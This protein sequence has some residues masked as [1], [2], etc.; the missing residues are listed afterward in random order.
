MLCYG[1]MLCY[2]IILTSANAEL[3]SKIYFKLVC[4]ARTGLQWADEPAW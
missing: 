3:C 1:V 4:S 2:S